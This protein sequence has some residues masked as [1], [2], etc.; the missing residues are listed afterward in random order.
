VFITVEKIYTGYGWY[1]KGY[2][3]SLKNKEYFILAYILLYSLQ[4]L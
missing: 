2:F 3:I 1:A 4:V